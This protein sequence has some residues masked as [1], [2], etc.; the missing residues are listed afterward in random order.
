MEFE[1]ETFEQMMETMSYIKKLP[2]IG[3]KMFNGMPGTPSYTFDPA[4]QRS[5][6]RAIVLR[7]LRPGSELQ[8]GAAV[9]KF[10]HFTTNDNRPNF[11]RALAAAAGQKN[12]FPV[13]VSVKLEG[14][15][16]T[17]IYDFIY[18]DLSYTE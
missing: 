1:F 6:P 17:H 18:R 11:Q 15:Y 8:F 3:E 10:L 2:I 7:D 12:L 13:A 14:T 5:T 16:S 9:A 4:T